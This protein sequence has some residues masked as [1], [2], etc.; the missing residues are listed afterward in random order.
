MRTCANCSLE[1]IGIICAD[2]WNNDIC[3]SCFRDSQ[4]TNDGTIQCPQCLGFSSF[5][6]AVTFGK[7]SPSV[8]PCKI[9]DGKGTISKAD[10][11]TIELEQYMLNT[12]TDEIPF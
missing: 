2:N 8:K 12:V 4:M 9:C 5:A 7:V 3:Y 6:A 10:V 11:G 1:I